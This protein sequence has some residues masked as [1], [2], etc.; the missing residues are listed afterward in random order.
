MSAAFPSS[1][2]VR[3]TALAACLTALPALGQSQPRCDQLAADVQSAISKDPSKTLMILEDALVIHETCAC[4][5][6]RAAIQASDADENMVQQI[7][8]TAIAVAPKMAPIITECAG[9]SEEGAAVPVAAAA[10]AAEDVL[11]GGK[12]GKSVMPITP[13]E[14]VAAPASDDGFGGSDFFSV[15]SNI[16]GVYLIAPGGVGFI[17]PDAVD[18]PEEDRDPDTPDRVRRRRRIPVSPSNA[19]Y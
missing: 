11:Q 7:V 3:L 15:P 1:L 5:I 17:N 18:E 14:E 8:Q 9:M 13:P 10:A 6:V 19:N 12:S 2:A 16:R 4:D